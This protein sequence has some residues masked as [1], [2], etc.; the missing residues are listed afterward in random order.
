MEA[1]L[2]KTTA[3]TELSKT[4]YQVAAEMTNTDIATIQNYYRLSDELRLFVSMTNFQNLATCLDLSKEHSID[5][6]F[7]QL[8]FAWEKPKDAITQFLARVKANPKAASFYSIVLV[9]Y[10]SSFISFCN[11]YPVLLTTIGY[12]QFLNEYVTNAISISLQDLNKYSTQMQVAPLFQNYAVAQWTGRGQEK[13]A[14]QFSDYLIGYYE[15]L[16]VASFDSTLQKGRDTIMSMNL[17]DITVEYVKVSAPFLKGMFKLGKMTPHF[18]RVVSDLSLN[19]LDATLGSQLSTSQMS[20]VFKLVNEKGT[21]ASTVGSLPMVVA[22]ER[23]GITGLSKMSQHNLMSLF[24]KSTQQSEDFLKS[25]FDIN[26]YLAATYK[27]D[28]LE[29]YLLINFP[30]MH[31][32]QLISFPNLNLADKSWMSGVTSVESYIAAVK[33]EFL[34]GM[35]FIIQSSPISYLKKIYEIDDYTYEWWPLAYAFTTYSGLPVADLYQFLPAASI[36]LMSSL[37]LKKL[38]LLGPK[39][40]MTLEGFST[41][42]IAST[43]N[44]SKFIIHLGGGGGMRGYIPVRNFHLH[45]FLCRV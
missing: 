40:T 41:S 7:Q 20:I 8:K 12:P 42:L 39:S 16:T 43:Q 27:R 15:G 4:L 21:M 11:T 36:N 44:M 35:K 26:Q 32:R 13:S 1:L 9:N 18:I 24:E 14:K 31:A 10:A 23:V 6:A 5:F 37:T 38:E 45:H 3:V 34:K 30:S 22:L 17:I 25:W 33:N 19:Q 29:K 28:K 2:N